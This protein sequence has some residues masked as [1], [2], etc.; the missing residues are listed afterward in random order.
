MHLSL[1]FP[2]TDIDRRGEAKDGSLITT[3]QQ[4]R[5]LLTPLVSQ[6]QYR[7]A[8]NGEHMDS[9]AAIRFTAKW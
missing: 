6:D 4:L 1:L 8:L 9:S 7:F 5:M 2:H 3:A